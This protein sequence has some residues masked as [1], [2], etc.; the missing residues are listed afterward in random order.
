MTRVLFKS[1]LTIVHNL[2]NFLDKIFTLFVN[3]LASC[4][5]HLYLIPNSKH[6]YYFIVYLYIKNILKINVIYH[7]TKEV[8]HSTIFSLEFSSS[9]WVVKHVLSA[10]LKMDKPQVCIREL[11]LTHFI[12]IRENEGLGSKCKNCGAASRIYTQYIC[13]Q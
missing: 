7:I 6:C 11:C 12:T 5:T 8:H 13:H 1:I 10:P 3:E 4:V 9:K 2:E